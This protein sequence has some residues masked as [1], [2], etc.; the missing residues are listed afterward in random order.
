MTI[1]S[2]ATAHFPLPLRGEFLDHGRRLRL[3]EPFVFVDGERRI[4]VPALF[5]T[6]FHSVPRVLWWWMP[7]WEFPFA[8]VIHDWLYQHP[9]DLPRQECD[10]IHRRILELEEMRESKRNAAYVGVRIGGRGA[11]NRYRHLEQKAKEQE[12]LLTAAPNVRTRPKVG[13]DVS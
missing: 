12:A 9:G 5:E 1:D 6:D 2:A 4:E 13:K 8:A 11:W 10:V 7:P 3:F